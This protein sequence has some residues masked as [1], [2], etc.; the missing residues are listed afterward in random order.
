MKTKLFIGLAGC[1]ITACTAS[2]E[3]VSTNIV[4]YLKTTATGNVNQFFTTG[5][6][7]VQPLSFQDIANAKWR[8]GD[9]KA[10]GFNVYS[11]FISTLNPISGQTDIVAVYADEATA[12]TW[13]DI[14]YVGWWDKA[15][16]DIPY[17]EE[18]F[19]LSEG[20][21]CNFSSSDVTL[22]YAGEVVAQPMTIG[23][24]GLKFPIISN[25]VP[26]EN[27]TLGDLKAEDFN[28]YSD[29]ISTLNPLTGATGIVAV[30]ADETT[31]I[32]WGDIDYVG[33][34]DKA[35]FDIPYDGE[36]LPPGTTFLG[37]FSSS[38]VKILF[39]SPF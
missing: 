5:P 13:G 12:I 39:P 9:V 38:N 26:K 37:N 18:L 7:F 16:F 31:A 6:T 1:L 25:F 35:T 17:D 20:F 29:F 34:W 2:A 27:M 3:V 11:D 23:F 19:D 22:T 32:A 4:G 24:A 14:D 21:L 33:W 10:E 36:P 8:L 30:Y 15:T 28:V